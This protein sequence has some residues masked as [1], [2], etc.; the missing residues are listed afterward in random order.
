MNGSPAS[1][2]GQGLVFDED[3]VSARDL[4]SKT[5]KAVGIA[6]HLMIA[7]VLDRVA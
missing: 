1:S 6:E 7:E 2:E 5:A 4:V 3:L